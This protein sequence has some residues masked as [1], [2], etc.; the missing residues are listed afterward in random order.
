MKVRAM[1]M[2]VDN[3]TA[4]Q[5]QINQIL[6]SNGQVQNISQLDQLTILAEATLLQEPKNNISITDQLMYQ[7]DEGYIFSFESF[8]MIPFDV[9][10][11][12]DYQDYRSIVTDEE[13]MK[14][15][16]LFNCRVPENEAE[17]KRTYDILTEINKIS[18][19]PLSYRVVNNEGRLM[20]LIMSAV[21]EKNEKNQ[22]V[23]LDFGHMFKKDFRGTVPLMVSSVMAKQSFKI[24]SVQK[25]VATSIADNYNAQAII[26]R[27]KFECI[28]QIQKENGPTVNVYELT[29]EKFFSEGSRRIKDVRS[30]VNQISG[31]FAL[32]NEIDLIKPL[33]TRV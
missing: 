26:L 2:P 21:L 19:M 27:R 8:K 13:L 31:R 6:T 17:I 25:I 15:I 30:Y 24:P 5:N 20:G 14:T 11:E 33:C 16:S 28:G 29:R 9:N 4:N 32:S 3:A 23:I 18:E 7:S 1:P 12:S 22:P 10:S